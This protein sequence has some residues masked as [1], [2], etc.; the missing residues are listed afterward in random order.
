VKVKHFV[1]SAAGGLAA[2]GLCAFMPLAADAQAQ[3]TVNGSAVD[4]SPAPIIQAG[5][6]FVPLRGVF[7]QL[8]ASVVY[9]NGTINAT[10]NGRDISLQ[11]G[12][13]Q[14]TVNGQPQVIDVAPFIVGE[15]TYVPLRFISEALG[16]SVSWDD[17]DSIAAIDT[18]GGSATYF[19][20]GTASYVDT[21]PP[22][23][24]SYAQPYVP[25]PNYIW[26]PG[27]WAW[28]AYGYYWVPGTWVQAPQPGYLWTPG[29]WQWNNGGYSWSPGYWALAI[30]FYGGVN[31]GGGYYGHGYDGGR[32]S[33][34]VFNYNTYVTRVNTTIVHNV[35]VTRNVYINNST[36]RISY[37]GGQTGLQARPT[38]EQL[39]VVRGRHLGMTPVQQ[40]HVRQAEQDRRLVATVNHNQPP[41]LAVARPL[42]PTNRPAG[43]VPVKPTERVNPQANVAP[44]HV[45]AARPEKHVP[46][47]IAVPVTHTQP[48]QVAP[49]AGVVAPAHMPTTHVVAPPYAPATHVVAPPHAPAV[50]VAP[51]ARAPA[52]EAVPPTAHVVAPAQTPA[53][54]VPRA[55]HAPSVREAVPNHVPAVFP[56]QPAQVHAGAP[57]RIRAASP[58]YA[59]AV[60][61]PAGHS[62]TVHAPP[63]GQRP[64]GAHGP[65]PHGGPN[66]QK[67]P[68]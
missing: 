26:Q 62:P 57:A 11:I 59:P 55:L 30:G 49:P 42:S 65:A 34:N 12:S 52:A 48:V 8:G 53:A 56:A 43:F 16:D 15:S 68:R 36:I 6:V 13:T 1:I 39:A 31:Y 18:G 2:L 45:P 38:P 9:S 14:A 61:A 47:R 10:G 23:I 51:P 5:R 25:A 3:I 22:A 37:N 60:H 17:A 29:Y 21:A 4:V 24:P 54:H 63:A 7:E 33:N 46:S 20:P 66:D 40:Q 64:S 28:G 44:V 27:Y 67:P 35:Y 58:G 19:T 41:V 50:H 32:W